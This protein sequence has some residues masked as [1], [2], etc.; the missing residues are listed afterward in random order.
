[1]ARRGHARKGARP[2]ARP[3]FDTHQPN[4]TRRP[5]VPRSK[6]SKTRSTS[7]RRDTLTTPKPKQNAISMSRHPN[8][9][10]PTKPTALLGCASPPPPRPPRGAASAVLVHADLGF[11][12]HA[13]GGS[14][15]QRVHADLDRS[16]DL[17]SDLAFPSAST[18]LRELASSASPEAR[19]RSGISDRRAPSARKMPQPASTHWTHQPGTGHHVDQEQA[20]VDDDVGIDALKKALLSAADD[21]GPP[22]LEARALLR[23]DERPPR[24]HRRRYRPR[25]LPRPGLRARAFPAVASRAPAEG[26]LRPL[27]ACIWATLRSYPSETLRPRRPGRRGSS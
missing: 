27:L 16:I 2:D 11:V 7:I 15:D 17:L 3:R 24:R 5:S 12:R 20:R 1:M 23:A 26:F 6:S 10:N 14:F 22:R 18:A 13:L 8:R 25:R 9:E 19:T 4:R 21:R